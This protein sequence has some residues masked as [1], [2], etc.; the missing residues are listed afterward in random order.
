MC[1][2]LTSFF[3]KIDLRLDT[4]SFLE[5]LLKV[6]D[7]QNS[8][9][10]DPSSTV[11]YILYNCEWVW[12]NFLLYLFCKPDVLKPDVLKPD[13]LSVYHMQSRGEG[14]G[15]ESRAANSDRGLVLGVGGL[16]KLDRGL[17]RGEPFFPDSD[18]DSDS[19]ETFQISLKLGRVHV[20]FFCLLDSQ[21]C[22]FR[23]N[24]FFIY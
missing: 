24:T 5:R 17:G 4:I 9:F 20:E 12:T 19:D 21:P 6:C 11:L 10:F 15:G 8:Q 3:C 22:N 16:G 2:Y 23:K 1:F 13:V 7:S 14:G 18:S